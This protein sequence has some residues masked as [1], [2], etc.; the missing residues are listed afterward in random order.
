MF[1]VNIIIVL[2]PLIA[3]SCTA[4][5]DEFHKIMGSKLYENKYCSG[6]Y[7]KISDA[8]LYG[9]LENGREILL[10]EAR[11]VQLGRSTGRIDQKYGEA[12]LKVDITIENGAVHSSAPYLDP[13]IPD[14][15]WRYRERLGKGTKED[16]WS[17]ISS[18]LPPRITYPCNK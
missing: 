8:G 16:F 14:A 7:F 18:G 15:F 11:L 5:E 6:K 9:H 13:P 3:A 10:K 4:N 2:C 12:I 1:R 17:K